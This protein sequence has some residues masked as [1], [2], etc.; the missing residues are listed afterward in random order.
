MEQNLSKNI[1]IVAHPALDGKILPGDRLRGSICWAGAMYR[2]RDK[3]LLRSKYVWRRC[4]SLGNKQG[5]A[6]P[7]EITDA[8]LKMDV[9]KAGDIIRIQDRTIILNSAEF[10]GNVLK[11][12]FTIE[13]RGLTD[14]EVSSMLSF[15][16]KSGMAHHLK[17]NIL[18][19]GLPL[20]EVLSQRTN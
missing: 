7:L 8:Q 10:Q 20:M 4:D 2:R 18:T 1:L 3:N 17:R 16:V 11:A 5:I 6:K 9:F 14:L 19:A 12:N 13:N 15:Y